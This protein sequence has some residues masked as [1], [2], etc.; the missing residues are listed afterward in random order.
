MLVV[1]TRTQADPD[2]WGHVLF[3]RDIVAQRAIPAVDHYSFTSDRPWINHEWLSEVSMYSAYALAG[4]SGL[5]LLKL[6]L[7]VA[8]IVVVLWTLRRRGMPPALHDALV[9]LT[10]A[11]IM[12]LATHIRPEMF[13]LLLFTV[14]LVLLTVAHRC[15]RTHMIPLMLC[16]ESA[17]GWLVGMKYVRALGG[18]R[19][20][21][22]RG[23]REPGPLAAIT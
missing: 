20:A 6:A 5:A 17:W 19:V 13:S 2:L 23:H 1:L 14:M 4:S 22:A 10:I 16:G 8:A 15:R 9:F 12:P 21:A 3:G 7:V 11:G 18:R